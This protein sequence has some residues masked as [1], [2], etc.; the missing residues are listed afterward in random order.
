MKA[1]ACNGCGECCRRV[2]QL[3]PSWPTRPDGACVHLGA[4]NRCA[5]YETRPLICRVDESRPASVSVEH[6][7]KLNADVCAQ[8]QRESNA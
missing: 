2:S 5:I 6:W 1:F 4:D 8:L 3:S 7:H